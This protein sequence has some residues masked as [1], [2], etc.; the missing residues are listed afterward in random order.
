MAPEASPYDLDLFVIGAGSAGVRAS[1]VAATLGAKVA[2]AEEKAL[3]GTCVNVG[4]VPK[5]LM[6]YGAHFAHEAR[7]AAGFGWSVG[8]LAH[9]WQTLI[10][11]KDRE[12]A[13]LNGVYERLLVDKGV[14]VLR[15]RATITGPNEVTVRA[16]DGSVSAHRARYI[17]VATGGIPVRPEFPGSELVAVSDD[18]FHLRSMPKRVVVVGG[19]YIAVEF[20]GVFSGYGAHVTLVHRGALFLRGFDRDVRVHLD[21]EMRKHGVDLRFKEDLARIERAPSGALV[22]TLASGA[23]VEA[24]L[25]LSAIGRKPLID[26]LG[27]REAGVELD[28]HGAIKVD[29]RFRTSA[30]SIYAIGDVIARIQLT[31]VALAEGIIV[32]RNLFAGAELR[33]DYRD[34]PSAVFSTP[35]IGTVGLTEEEALDE[36]GAIDVYRST[37]TPLKATLGKSGEKTLMK[38]IV[39]KAT[40][41]VVGVHVVGPDAAEIV[42][43]FAVALKCG[44][45]KKQFDA[46]IGIHPTA[47]EELVTMREPI[48]ERR[49]EPLPG[50]KPRPRHIVH[51]RWEDPEAC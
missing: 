50:E 23:R 51:H 31:P 28:Q 5:K 17:L 35:P 48:P 4:C 8:P 15:G 41:R 7:D 32:A 22:V 20:A 16:P 3:G 24:D 47:G 14:R 27:L 43:G 13:R 26:G 10:A 38:L 46:T 36:L 1:R 44:A 39:E 2:V 19:G 21:D 30:R 42:Q 6:V 34:V 37:F 11:N 49:I 40:D 25:V 45:T 33:A 18:V 9:D 12:I 29:E